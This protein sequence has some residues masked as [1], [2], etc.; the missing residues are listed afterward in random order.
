MLTPVLIAVRQ[1]QGEVSLLE[2][3]ISAVIATMQN[4]A[5]DLNIDFEELVRRS[6]PLKFTLDN[7]G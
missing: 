2:A 5:N 1:L 6:A 4:A 7:N 3:R